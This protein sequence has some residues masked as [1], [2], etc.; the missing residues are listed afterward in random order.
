MSEVFLLNS[1]SITPKPQ[2]DTSQSPNNHGLYERIRAGQASM[3]SERKHPNFK[4]LLNR[5]HVDHG[6]KQGEI[7][8]LQGHTV[9]THSCVAK[10]GICL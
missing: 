9:N 10:A 2:T 7:L 4:L 1:R 3:S 6:N 8:L 5:R